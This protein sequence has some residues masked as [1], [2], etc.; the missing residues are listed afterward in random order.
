MYC[1]T[2]DQDQL[3]LTSTAV[4]TVT[5]KTATKLPLTFFCHKLIKVAILLI[6]GYLARDLIIW[7][8]FGK[9]RVENISA[10]TKESS[11]V[12]VNYVNNF[13]N[14]PKAQPDTSPLFQYS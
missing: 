7:S 1:H 6:I 12:D 8:S 11:S 4:S 13:D 9:E 5:L 10:L 14:N 2:T 3:S